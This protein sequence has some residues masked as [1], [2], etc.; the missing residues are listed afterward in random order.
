MS[1]LKKNRTELG[2]LCG[3]LVVAIVAVFAITNHSCAGGAV[4]PL[5]GK[6][7]KIEGPTG[8]EIR[9][10][11]LRSEMTEAENNKAWALA[12]LDVAKL[13]KGFTQVDVYYETQNGVLV[14]KAD[15]RVVVRQDIKVYRVA[16]VARKPVPTPGPAAVQEGRR[17]PPPGP[18]ARTY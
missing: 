10:T 17:Q 12:A 5:A 14:T 11:I 13:G 2:V 6:P 9:V 7:Y 8:N 16:P 15:G 4:P 18:P 3:V 1:W